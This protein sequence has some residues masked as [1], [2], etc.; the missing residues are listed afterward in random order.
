M[1]SLVENL[2]SVGCGFQHTALQTNCSYGPPP[3]TAVAALEQLLIARHKRTDTFHVIA[4]PRLMNPWWRR[5]FNKV[6]DFTVVISPD[7]SFWPENMYEPLWLGIV[8]PFTRHRPWCFKRSPL[9]V[10]MGSDLRKVLPTR[11]A[12]ARPL[13]RKLLQLLKRVAS[14]PASMAR[15][16]LHVPGSRY[17]PDDGN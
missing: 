2:T 17:L 11:E 15:G 16:V 12:D 8:L 1:A 13:L 14:L 6:C 5:L 7:V 10:E 9:L 4:I 3:T